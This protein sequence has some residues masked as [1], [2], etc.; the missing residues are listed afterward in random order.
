MLPKLTTDGFDGAGG[1]ALTPTQS[2]VLTSAVFTGM[3]IG[4]MFAGQL[5]DK[6]GRKPVLMAS[7]A[8]NSIGA[9]AVAAAPNAIVL[10]CFRAI[11]GAGVGGSVPCVFALAA[12]VAPDFYREKLLV[13]VASFWMVGSVFTASCSWIILGGGLA[14]WRVFSLITALPAAAAC[15]LLYFFVPES[16]RFLAAQ[17]KLAAAAD[18]IHFIAKGMPSCDKVTSVTQQLVGMQ[19]EFT[20]H[21]RLTKRMGPTGSQ[22][23]SMALL[24][25]ADFRGSMLVL[26][27]VWF[28]LSF[29]SYGLGTY[30][31]T[32]FEAIGLTDP[33]RCAFIYAA[34]N[35]PG[36]LAAAYLVERPYF[37]KHGKLN[38]L[39]AATMTV[40]SASAVAFAFSRDSAVAVLISACVFN[41]ASI[42]GWNVLDCISCDPFPAAI[43]NSAL[44][45][46]SSS[47]RV[48]SI[49]A[50]FTNGYLA[51]TS[52]ATLLS[53]TA[54]V[55]FAGGAA[56]LLL[57]FCQQADD[58][59][60]DEGKSLLTADQSAPIQGF[61][62][63][64]RL[65]SPLP[66]RAATITRFH[67]P[68]STWTRSQRGADSHPLD[69]QV[70]QFLYSS[71][72][73]LAAPVRLKRAEATHRGQD[74]A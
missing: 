20:V 44:G 49:V 38:W 25:S 68:G 54:S 36:N 59:K 53:V 48:G 22:P 47:G 73:I 2:S 12:E 8:L 45:I 61:N 27:V 23:S 64:I 1:G 39:M 37:K 65:T 5:S 17:G 58:S 43:R 10:I 13:M 41:A 32:L 4:G 30:I 16:P 29:G 67:H 70:A 15:I 40:A 33:Y 51:T 50:M 9:A 72:P 11:A 55:M 19:A 71:A 60:Q 28:A 42:C 31:T 14:S 26:C 21:Q 18:S 63:S 66:N 3:L 69:D 24:L 57:L 34:S 6:V 35:L 62:L 52:V 74:A 7:L 56:V 46:I